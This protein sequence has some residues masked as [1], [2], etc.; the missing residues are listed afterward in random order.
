MGKYL[1]FLQFRYGVDTY[2]YLYKFIQGAL[3]YKEKMEW[4]VTA[5]PPAIIF[6]TS[7]HAR[8][9]AGPFW[10][11]IRTGPSTRE[12]RCARSSLIKVHLQTQASPFPKMEKSMEVSSEHE[13]YQYLNLIQNILTNGEHR[14]DRYE[15]TT[16]PQIFMAR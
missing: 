6:T 12:A 14:P 10:V 15:Y 16:D 9:T 2:M 4:L 11:P 8:A 7:Y 13:E 1:H 5:P 3:S